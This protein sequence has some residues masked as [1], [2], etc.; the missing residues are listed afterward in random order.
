MSRSN[1]HTLVFFFSFLCV[2]LPLKA[3][4]EIVQKADQDTI[5]KRLALHTDTVKPLESAAPK[6]FKPIPKTAVLLGLIPGMG[7]VY[8]RKY[9]K[10]PLVYGGLMA[11]FYAINWN[12]GNYQDYYSAYIDIYEDSQHPHDP[13]SWKESW[14]NLLPAGVDPANYVQDQN[15]HDALKRK[16]DFYRR[17]RDLSII[18]SVGVYALS[19][20]DAYVDAQ[21]FDFD[22]SEDLSIQMV[23][24]VKP[25]TTR[26]DTSYGF[27][28]KIT[29]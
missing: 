1:F 12:H 6:A 13:A 7:Q 15:F 27:N 29:F 19:L 26:T 18:I 9:W 23:P 14:Q 22:I 10:L 21:L 3:L 2:C 8:N 17:Y 24:E 20:V 25:P 16:K 5:V 11:C 28:C 4:P